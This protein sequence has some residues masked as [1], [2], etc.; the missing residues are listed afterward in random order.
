[1]AYIEGENRNQITLFPECMDDYVAEDNI[2]RVIDK[3]VNNL[4]MEKLGFQRATPNRIGAPSYDPRD[5][6]KLY[7]YSYLNKLR[8]SRT[9]ER[10]AHRNIELIWLIN[11]LKPDFKTIADFRK[12]N[13]EALKNLFNEFLLLCQKCN[14]IGNKF[15]AI[16]GSYFKAVNAQ[17][18]HFTKNKVDKRLKEIEKTTEEYLD[19]LDKMDKV[20][21][22]TKNGPTTQELLKKLDDLKREKLKLSKIKE[23]IQAT[24][25]DQLC[26]TDPDSCVMRQGVGYN[27]QIAV[28][29]ENS[30]IVAY[31][32]T[33]S[34]VDNN[35]L[36]N[37]A[38][39]AKEALNTE[40]LEVVADT[41]YYNHLE[42]KECV[43]NQITPY[44]SEPLKTG[45]PEINTFFSKSNFTYDK[46][47]DYY[48]CPCSYIMEC[49]EIS[50][51]K[52]GGY[53]KLYNCN[54]VLNCPMKAKCTTSK[55]GRYIYR[56]E[57][58]DIIDEMKER[59][60]K[61]KEKAKKRKSIVE[62]PFGTIK[63]AMDQGYFLMKGKPKVNA[64]FA[65]TSFTY[66]L[67]RVYNIL[68]MQKLMEAIG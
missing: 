62:H 8:S 27:V 39:K 14:L 61:D 17:N 50:K 54:N 65:T 26:T 66:N 34:P 25:K 21:D 2:V 64:E 33:D 46:T 15:V 4:D 24:G 13:K 41:G 32:V 35:E 53:K 9:M 42:I 55:V 56:W 60:L 37:M 23:D 18:R 31:E 58:E 29:K 44:V 36:S 38:K 57:H 52:K 22:K 68:G 5:L 19:T 45:N 12:D 20:E 49:K 10:E 1:M 16:D 48:I 47:N 67:K 63:R 40:S 11:K 3:Y 30:L 28:D 43:D 59:M 6:L 51:D 7:I